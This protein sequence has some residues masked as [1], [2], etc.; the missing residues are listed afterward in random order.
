MINA[1]DRPPG[2]MTNDE[3]AIDIVLQSGKKL[4]IDTVSYSTIICVKEI[5]SEEEGVPVE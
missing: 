2:K 1:S 3:I 5:I 4:A